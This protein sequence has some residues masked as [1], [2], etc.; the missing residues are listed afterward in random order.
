[1]SLLSADYVFNGVVTR[2]CL[3][4]KCA[5]TFD[6]HV[7]LY[8]HFFHSL[9]FIILFSVYALARLKNLFYLYISQF[10]VFLVVVKLAG[11]FPP[12]AAVAL[13]LLGNSVVSGDC[14]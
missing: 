4:N 1:M 9:H 6:E 2:W 14:I 7:V 11:F 12:L 3:R 10:Q 5:L 13:L 8:L